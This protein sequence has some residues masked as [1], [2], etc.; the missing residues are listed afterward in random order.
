MRLN[1]SSLW[2]LRKPQQLQLEITLADGTRSL[3]SFVIEPNVTSDIWFYPWN[4]ADLAR[5]FDADES[6]WRASGRPAVTD[7]RLL[8]TPLDW[9]SQKPE[10]IEIKSADAVGLSLAH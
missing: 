4:E 5:Y 10:S 6:R 2:K 9:F 8:I 1:Y 7:L 3:R